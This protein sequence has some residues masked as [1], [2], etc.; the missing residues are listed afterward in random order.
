MSAQEPQEHQETKQPETSETPEIPETFGMPVATAYQILNSKD[1]PIEVYTSIAS[2]LI[3]TT[4]L[5]SLENAELLVNALKQ[6]SFARFN[7]LRLL[8]VPIVSVT[9][10]TLMGIPNAHDCHLTT[11]L[12]PYHSVSASF[13]M[14][15]LEDILCVEGDS[16]GVLRAEI[17]VNPMRLSLFS[18]LKEDALIKL[19][20]HVNCVPET[21]LRDTVLIGCARAGVLPRK[22]T[23][24]LRIQEIIAR[25]DAPSDLA[26]AKKELADTQEELA[27]T[28]EELAAA[29]EYTVRIAALE[30]EL[31]KA[32]ANEAAMLEI[33]HHASKLIGKLNYY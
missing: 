29:G 16:L 1:T 10:K 31:A 30:A 6:N 28:K 22:D 17:D 8:G 20:T 13:A 33:L 3:P 14:H 9:R 4:T 5:D 27:K 24:R 25:E 26:K 32:N 21:E 19:Y 23:E 18:G 2:I 7:W 15:F 12:S 11:V